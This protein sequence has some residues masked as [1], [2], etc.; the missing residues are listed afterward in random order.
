MRQLYYTEKFQEEK[1]YLCPYCSKGLVSK[2]T[3]NSDDYDYKND[4]WKNP[5]QVELQCE[6][7]G[8]TFNEYELK[9]VVD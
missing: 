2:T 4:Y 7:C 3:Q 9:I 5:P 1:D 6:Y 8:H